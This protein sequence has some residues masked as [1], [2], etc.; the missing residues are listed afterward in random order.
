[1][2]VSQE[3]EDV[4]VIF[5]TNRTIDIKRIDN[6]HVNDI[7]IGNVGGVVSTQKGPVLSIMHQ[8]ALLGKGASIHSP[9]QLKWYK[10]WYMFLAAST[11]YYLGWLR[12]SSY[13]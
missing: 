2:E 13:Y 9:S 12:H 7:G 1:M 3:K 5:R 11:A 6:H 10:N 4:R 8:Y